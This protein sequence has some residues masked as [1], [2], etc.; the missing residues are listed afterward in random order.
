MSSLD[1]PTDETGLR[2]SLRAFRHR[3][4]RIFWSAALV[5]N[6]GSWLANLT[7]PYVLYDLTHSAFWVGLA[8]LAQFLPGVV[9]AP[10]GGAL[11]DRHDRRRVLLVAQT[12]LAA[13]AVALWALWVSGVRDPYA[14][15][16][17]VA[18]AGT[19]HGVN[20]P[21]WQSFVHDL[22]PRRDLAS[23][24]GLNSLQLNAARAV[25]PAVA[26]VLLATLGP[27]WAFLFNAVSFAFVI[28]ALLLVRTSVVVSRQPR[29]SLVEGFVSAVLYIRAQ[30]GIQCAILVSVLVGILGNPIFGFTVVFASDV[31]HVGAVGLGGLNAVLG[32]GSLIAA[33]IVTGARGGSLGRTVRWA[34]ILFALAMG[35]FAAAPNV[36]TGGVA[37]AV[38]GG[39]FLS[40]VSSANTAMQLIVADHMR[41]R[42]LAVRIMLFTLSFPV[43]SL[44]QGWVSDRMGPRTAV[45][46]ASAVML[47]V[48]LFLA[49]WR[50]G[51]ILDRL[52]DPHDE[53]LPADRERLPAGRQFS[54]LRHNDWSPADPGSTLRGDPLS[55]PRSETQ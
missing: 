46:G 37:L 47:L 54:T 14:I 16:A 10:Y 49:F 28:A 9:M 34:F 13:A 32:I 26:G 38:V 23:A 27:G 8:A 31:F 35:G 43:G 21:A 40:V 5:S 45:L 24:V 11:A 17:L 41:G 3:E 2:Y 29:S 36:W 25:G 18:V 52:D 4:F 39:C 48:G 51:R 1:A 12:G 19:F 15:L 50:A 30:P 7:V 42:V 33:L 44:G 53:A 22:V 20:L 55:P 6:T